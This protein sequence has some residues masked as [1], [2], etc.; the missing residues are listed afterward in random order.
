M[1][2]CVLLAD[3]LVG[4]DSL[5]SVYVMRAVCIQACACVC[6]YAICFGICVYRV[7]VYGK[8]LC[9][10]QVAIFANCN[11]TFTFLCHITVY[12]K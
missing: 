3:S 5:S 2:A 1:C 11:L 7:D 12:P 8:Q 10:T 4:F 6:V 9:G